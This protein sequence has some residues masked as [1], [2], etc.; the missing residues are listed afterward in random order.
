MT[1]I[2]YNVLKFVRGRSGKVVSV[3]DEQGKVFG[4][5]AVYN[6]HRLVHGDVRGASIRKHNES[7]K[8]KTVGWLN[9]TLKDGLLKINDPDGFYIGAFP[10]ESLFSVILHGTSF[11][12]YGRKKSKRYE[13]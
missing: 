6:I 13:S 9:R 11:F 10:S 1:G 12:V 7:G 8:W 3:F 4:C 5:I 2:K